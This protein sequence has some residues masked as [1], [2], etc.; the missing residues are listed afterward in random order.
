MR[1]QLKRT[2]Q[3]NLSYFAF[4][5]TPKFKTLAVFNEAGENGQRPSI[6]TACARRSKRALSCDVLQSYTCYKRYYQ[7]I[8]QVEDDPEVPRRKTARALARF[9]DLHDYNIAQKVEVIV[10]HFRTH[11]RHKIGGRAKAMVVTSS[12]EHAVRYKLA[13]DQYLSRAGL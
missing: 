9:V 13:F 1:E 12:R 8:Q 5:A 7:L 2:K 11:T 10:E 4:T 3:P 6:S